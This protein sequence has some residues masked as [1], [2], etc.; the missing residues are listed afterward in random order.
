MN[1]PECGWPEHHCDC[2]PAKPCSRAVSGSA[3]HFAQ[4]I[5]QAVDDARQRGDGRCPMCQWVFTSSITHDERHPDWCGYKQAKDALND[6][7]MR[8]A[9]DQ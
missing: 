7:A 3:H 5:V 8:P 1:C 4:L 6:Q 9:N 2:E